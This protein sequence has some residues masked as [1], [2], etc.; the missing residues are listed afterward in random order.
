MKQ[1]HCIGSACEDTC[2][3]GW[4]VTI[5]KKT[6]KKYS[7]SK[8]SDLRKL[9]DESIQRNRSHGSDYDYGKIKLQEDGRCP[10]LTE[11]QWCK[12]HGTLGEDYL[13]ITCKTYPREYNTIN[14]VL[15]RSATTSCPEIARLALLDPNAMEF[16]EI[17]ELVDSSAIRGRNIN[18]EDISHQKQVLKFFWEL[19]IF[20]IGI[21]QA[22]EYKL[23]ERLVILGIFYQSIQEINAT[24]SIAEIPELILEYTTG[25]EKGLFDQTL[26]EVPVNEM[27]QI[28]L[29]KNIINKKVEQGINSKRYVEC[30]NDF[31]KGLKPNATETYAEVIANYTNACEFYYYPFMKEREYILENYLVNYVFKNSF[32]FSKED[33]FFDNYVL[34][35]LHYALIKMHLIGLAAYYKADFSEEIIIKLIQSFGKVIEH[36]QI[37]LEDTLKFVKES[38][39]TTLSWMLLLI[40]N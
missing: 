21:L 16:L 24:G 23:W 12:I 18:T 34:M 26:Q 8:N 29:L 19:R 3:A 28:E 13:S 30:F 40:K 1:F 25:I 31:V 9:F 37:F 5:D 17:E 7:K 6:Y 35:V 33:N 14:G 10:F 4:K 11:D 22:R 38:G 15:E 32:P 20:T 27:V 36:N 2:C 39:F